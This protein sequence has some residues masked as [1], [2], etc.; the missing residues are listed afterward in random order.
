MTRAIVEGTFRQ[1][2][3]TARRMTPYGSGTTENHISGRL[4]E[5][6]FARFRNGEPEADFSYEGDRRRGCDYTDPAG[7]RWHVR[8]TRH[9]NGGLLIRPKDPHGNYV[10]VVTARAPKC[11]IAGWITKASVDSRPLVPMRCDPG[12]MIWDVPQGD[13]HPFPE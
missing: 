10:L 9:E 8:S 4:A 6:V 1:D 2:D 12:R 11:R 13:L 3:A 7:V 5:I